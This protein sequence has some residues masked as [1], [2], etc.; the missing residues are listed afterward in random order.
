MDVVDFVDEVDLVDAE[1]EIRGAGIFPGLP[2]R[3]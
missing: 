1:A 2:F 3:L